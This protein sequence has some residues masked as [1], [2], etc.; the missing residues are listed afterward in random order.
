MS[1]MCLPQSRLLEMVSPF[2]LSPPC[3]TRSHRRTAV[4]LIRRLLIY[5][6]YERERGSVVRLFPEGLLTALVLS[7]R[8]FHSLWH[9]AA[10]W[11]ERIDPVQ[12]IL[13][14]AILVEFG[15]ELFVRHRVKRFFEVQNEDIF[16]LP[17]VNGTGPVFYY[18]HKLGLAA[19]ILSQGMLSCVKRVVVL[20]CCMRFEHIICSNILQKMHVSKT[21]QSLHRKAHMSKRITYI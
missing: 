18:I 6:L 21:G 14:Y 7:T 12:G 2:D 20:K 9:T 17:V 11:Q 13:I 8:R 1:S 5:H 16:L 4:C 19:V 3:S 15:L 10:W